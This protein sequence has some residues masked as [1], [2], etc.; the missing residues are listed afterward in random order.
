MDSSPC[1]E[2]KGV[3]EEIVNGYAKVRISSFAACANC[4]AKASCGIPEGTTRHIEVP[5]REEVFSEGESVLVNMKRTMGMKATL[6]AYIV[7]FVL[8]ITTLLILT[9][10]HITELFSGLISLLVLLPY[11]IGL[12]FF[13]DHLRRSFIFTLRKVI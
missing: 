2:Q 3:I 4:F 13:S 9:S 7:P 11:F 5:V 10:F 8:V 1:I 12:Y 6:I